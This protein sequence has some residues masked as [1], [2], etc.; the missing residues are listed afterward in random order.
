[1]IEE[2]D[3]VEME[4]ASKKRKQQGGSESESELKR[5]KQGHSDVKEE[6][7]NVDVRPRRD[8]NMTEAEMTAFDE[9][10][11]E[12][13][14]TFV[15]IEGELEDVVDVATVSVKINLEGIVDLL[16]TDPPYNTRREGG[17]ENSDYDVFTEKDMKNLADVANTILNPGGHGL[18]F[19]SFQQFEKYREILLS[20]TE[21]ELDENTGNNYRIKEVFTVEK[22]PLVFIRGDGHFSNPST[23]PICHTNMAEICVHFWKKGA[24]TADQKKR[25]DYKTPSEFGG[26]LPSWTN[27]VTGVPIPTGTE[28]VTYEVKENG[29]PTKRKLRPEQKPVSLLKYLINKFTKPGDLVVDVCAGIFSTMRACMEMEKHRRFVGCDKDAMCARIVQDEMIRFF[30]EQVHNQFSDITVQSIDIRQH[31]QTVVQYCNQAEVK[32]RADAWSTPPG[33]FPQQNF[34]PH[35]VQAFCQH[36]NDFSLYPHRHIPMNKWSIEAIQRMNSMDPRVLRSFEAYEK[37]LVV[38]PSSIKHDHV[39][40]GVF[41]SKPFQKGDV[42]CHYYVTIIYG[43]LGQKGRVHKR[44]GTGLLSV[45]SEEFEKW[46]LKIQG[47]QFVDRNNNRYDGYVAPAP[48]CVA[49][50]IN[51]PRYTEEDKEYAQYKK[52]LKDLD[53]TIQSTFEPR[54]ANVEFHCDTTGKRNKDFEKYTSVTI[55]A[56]DFIATDSELFINYGDAYVFKQS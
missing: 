29:E 8:M 17:A 43:D 44:Y 21:K 6:P 28:V 40:L 26:T 45:T 39:G 55:V 7:L 35:I 53:T 16:L 14:R 49:R 34:P 2:D 3:D 1:M 4:D 19:C 54:K 11:D 50:Y 25:L 51:D 5:Q 30:S 47:Y 22:A 20:I 52:H 33:L 48:F 9:V 24:S 10:N 18:I 37:K 56:T 15:M 38:K 12:M 23:N 27:V 32:K 46:S 13:E 31:T 42:I 36:Y 41:T